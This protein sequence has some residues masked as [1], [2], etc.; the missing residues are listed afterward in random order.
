MCLSMCVCVCVCVYRAGV[1]PARPG[2]K[3]PASAN[4]KRKIDTS[5][6]TIT[7]NM[8]ECDNTQQGDNTQGD[9]TAT[10]E[11]L[12]PPQEAGAAASKAKRGAGVQKKAASQAA[13][14][15]ADTLVQGDG[16]GAGR[17]STRARQ[18]KG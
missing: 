8:D 7:L 2:Q 12:P 5:S 6:V 1:S 15:D 17:G 4:R 16:T 9:D 14:V 3:P 13:G 18:K 11:T 10:D